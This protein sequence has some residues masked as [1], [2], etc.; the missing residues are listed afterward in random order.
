VKEAISYRQQ[1]AAARRHRGWWLL[2]GFLLQAIGAGGVAA[3]LWIKV[4]HEDLGGHITTMMVRLA[5]HSEVHTRQGLAVLI[6]GAIVYAAGSVVMARPYVTNPVTLLV[7]V[8][9]AAVIGLLVLG[10]LALIV[11]LIV[12]LAAMNSDLGDINFGGGIGGPGKTK[13]KQ[14]HDAGAAASGGPPGQG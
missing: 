7:A 4:R 9:V 2:G 11:A 14:R 10:V 8:P 5:W 1:A 3:F 6:A 13:R 12:S